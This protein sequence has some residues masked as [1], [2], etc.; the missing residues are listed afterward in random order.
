MGFY[1]RKS[2]RVGPFRFNL[3]KS[4]IGTSV[5]IK[6]FRLGTGPR[7]NYVHMGRGGVYFRQTLASK[8]QPGQ[9]SE[10]IPRKDVLPPETSDI[11]QLQEIESGSAL[12]MADSSSAKL[13]DEINSKHKKIKL[14]PASLI[15]FTGVSLVM[16][17]LAGTS[18]PPWLLSLIILIGLVGVA[19][20]Y[21]RD[22]VAKSVVILYD[23][24][25]HTMP[26]YQ[27]V[28][29]AF[30]QLSACSA[31][32]HIEAS[33]RVKD[34]KYHAGASQVVRRNAIRL[35]KGK[36]PVIKTNI[37]VPK[38]PVGKQI[39]A[40]MPDRLLVFEPKAVGA[41]PYYELETD[42]SDVRFIEEDRVPRDAEVVDHTWRYVNKSGGPDRRFKDN[43]RLPIVLYQEILFQS[44]SGLN[45]LIQLSRIG[46]GDPVRDALASL[47]ELAG[48]S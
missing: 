21:Y 45:E 47:A 41:V 30:D 5:G 4:G 20:A 11:D 38:I 19:A 8:P 10:A 43:P 12:E 1:V 2:V 40:F 26:V 7:G 48:G 34:R 18:A 6:G 42:V 28:L 3:S 36:T 9:D 33:G 14:L 35:S 27:K 32:W 23:L 31:A 13:L 37:D 29:E 39:L 15:L 44:P 24:D 17:L 22:K 16:I 25:E 46:V